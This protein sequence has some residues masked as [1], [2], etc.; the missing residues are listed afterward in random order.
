MP[1]LVPAFGAVAAFAATPLG[2]IAINAG[3]MLGASLLANWLKPKTT[4]AQQKAAF[5]VQ[6]NVMMGEDLPI[7]F[8]VGQT[9]TAGSRKYIN[10]WGNVDGVPNAYLVEVIQL[11]DIP[12]SGISGLRV[13]G[14]KVVIADTGLTARGYP[15]TTFRKSG[16]DHMW[17]KFRD[18][19]ETTADSY[20]LDKFE[21][22]DNYPWDNTCIGRGCPHVIITTLLNRE[23]FSQQ[24]TFFIDQSSQKFYDLRKDDTNGGTGSHRWD[25][26]S[27]WEPTTNAAIV[28]YNIIRGVYYN[29]EWIYGG[30]NIAAFRLPSASFIAAANVCD[31]AISL[32]AGGTEPQYRCGMTIYGDAEPLSVIKELLKAC[33]AR[34]CE[35]GG[36]F[37]ILAGAPGAATYAFTDADIVVTRSQSY[38]PF[39]SLSETFN[40][41]EAQYPEPREM[42]VM[43][44]APARNNAAW[45]ASDG[46][47]RLATGLQ[48]IAVPFAVQVQR[49][50]ASAIAENRNW[51]IHV[52]GLPP[53]AWVVTG[54]TVLAWTSAANGYTNKK[55]IPLRITGEPG[56]VQVAIILEI[57]PDDYGWISSDELPNPIGD[58]VILRPAPQPITGWAAVPAIIYD[59][60]GNPRR[61]GIQIS[62]DGNM[63]D[64]RA[65]NVVV[66]LKDT[67]QYV[68]DIEIPFKPPYTNLIS[69][70][71]CLPLTTY[72]VTGRYLPYSGRE[73]LPSVPIEVPTGPFRFGAADIVPIEVAMLGDELKAEHRLITS[74]DG[75]QQQ[76][77]AIQA[78]YDETIVAITMGMEGIRQSLSIL[79]AQKDGAVA[80]VIRNDIAI[81]NEAEARAQAI[82]EV[83]AAMDEVLADG[84]MS[85]EALVNSETAT[86]TV[87][88][89]ARAEKERN[90][91]EA[92]IMLRA[93]A[94]D[95]LAS[96]A[97]VGVLGDFYIFKTLTDSA[98]IR[99]F[100]VEDGIVKFNR[101]ESFAKNTD[102]S[103]RIIVNG[104]TGF[105]S[106]SVG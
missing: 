50:M 71:W 87:T 58:L 51:R 77:E 75:I 83:V 45:Q 85:I 62:Y 48:F 3:I 67:L 17:I 10:T 39:R 11:A 63:P 18:G 82:V 91:A 105:F 12:G 94:A 42:F 69:G 37:E 66:Q 33:S 78:A 93:A 41:I 72:L 8:P 22:D 26:Q 32:E 84:Y 2:S 16:V 13:N 53:S 4:E 86:A 43:K 64:I 5:G 56:F 55:F 89:G 103:S 80:A 106:I 14:E 79:K 98:P 70:E 21:D 7:S 49:L 20:L 35:I 61:N 81:A 9:G 54:T 73:T 23:L 1:F 97:Q 95:G 76:L 57:D 34:M 65:V 40:S 96:V 60:A 88:I 99:V 30:R 6:L 38:T 92:K 104:Q 101:L 36:I 19:T 102:G 100:G 74:S 68:S 46:G 59:E 25:D 29:G 31:E 52:I 90:V 28:A 24:P 47:R 44:D 27:T 15:V